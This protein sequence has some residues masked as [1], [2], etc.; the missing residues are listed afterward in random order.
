MIVLNTVLSPLRENTYPSQ[1]TVWSEDSYPGFWA[2][3]IGE[4]DS[5]IMNFVS[6]DVIPI[7]IASIAILLL[8]IWIIRKDQNHKMLVSSFANKSTQLINE[9]VKNTS[10]N[11]PKDSQYHLT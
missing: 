1:P 9:I 7:I 11:I 4:I 5:M 3:P 2:D 6:F 8:S 10:Y